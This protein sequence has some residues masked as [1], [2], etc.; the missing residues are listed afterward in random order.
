M[1]AG[2]RDLPEDQAQARHEVETQVVLHPPQPQES[3][4]ERMRAVGMALL[5]E[6]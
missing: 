2:G 4:C 3:T 6:R 5:P 1:A